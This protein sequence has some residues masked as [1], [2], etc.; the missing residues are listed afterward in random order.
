MEK[1]VLSF[2]RQSL[3]IIAFAVVTGIF[4]LNMFFFTTISFDLFE[5][6]TN[7][8]ALG[9]GVFSLV[10]ACI[11]FFLL[12]FL[13]K[14]I[15]ELDEKKL[16]LF[17]TALYGIAALYFILNIDIIIRDD[18]DL[19]AQ[20]AIQLHKGSYDVIQYGY[21]RMFPHQIGLV[22]YN[23]L[24]DV[25]SRNNAILFVMNYLFVIGTNYT[26]FSIS[27][28]LFDDHF[29]N[30]LTIFLSFLFLPQ[31]FFIF[32][33]YNNVPSFFFLTLAFYHLLRFSSTRRMKPMLV[34]V[35][36][37]AAAVLLRK[38]TM[39]GV[40]AMI[41]F[42]L[43]KMLK[44]YSHK[45]LLIIVL[46]ILGTLFPSK[47]V[48]SYYLQK[49]GAE[50]ASVPSILWVAMGT[51]IDNTER[52]PGWYDASVV[53]V[54]WKANCDTETAHNL[55]LQKIAN[56]V[57]KIRQ[58]PGRAAKFFS[59]KIISTWCDPLFQSVWS[60]PLES[61]EQKTYTSL[62]YSLYNGYKVEQLAA[63]FC[64][65]L[66]IAL[67]G[68]LGLFLLKY[69]SRYSGWEPAF[70]FLVGGFLFHIFWETKSQ[71]T[72]QYLLGLVPFAACALSS[73]AKGVSSRF[74]RTG[75]K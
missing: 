75:R 37:A 25:F 49:A 39:I 11:C 35:L 46:L 20:A 74:S 47:M 13:R 58:E 24:L 28:F 12:V 54:Y 15:E 72:Y 38:N 65:I 43:L 23:S 5:D 52:G 51:D 22:A 71:Y 32:F 10:L 26:L 33:A 27:K 66:S 17:F 14:H 3:C 18:A 70:T 2:L 44:K 6:V 57:Q 40:V 29:T 67:W 21:L 60:G 16:F 30:V 68:L 56:N 50:E 4:V 59:D 42:L 7:H 1:K 73:L 8:P 61:C 53:T 36:G 9:T 41:I 48:Y 62:L 69:G 55:G 19:V 31:F 45:H 34:A 63:F 64:R